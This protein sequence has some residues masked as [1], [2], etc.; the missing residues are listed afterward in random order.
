MAES[1]FADKGKKKRVKEI[2]GGTLYIP[3]NFIQKIPN[4]TSK[5]QQKVYL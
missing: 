1:K 5:V 4:T 3:L 2:L